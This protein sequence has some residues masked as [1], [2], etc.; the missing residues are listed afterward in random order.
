MT[1]DK[2]EIPGLRE[3][4]RRY[5]RVARLLGPYWGSYGRLAG[6]GLIVA[7]VGLLSPQFT[8]VLVDRVFPGADV[9]LLGAV[10][11]AKRRL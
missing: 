10:V 4:A 3:S 2:R 1:P 5:A 7:G 9:S 8:R 11:L 6:L